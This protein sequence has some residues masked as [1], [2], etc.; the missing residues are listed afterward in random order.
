MSKEAGNM[1]QNDNGLR[2][3]I[4]FIASNIMIDTHLLMRFTVSCHMANGVR[5]CGVNM[6]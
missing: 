3:Q 5:S 4:V 6:R 1:R 2:S